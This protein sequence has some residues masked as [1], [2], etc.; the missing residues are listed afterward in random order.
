MSRRSS[1]NNTETWSTITFFVLAAPFRLTNDG[2]CFWQKQG[3][4]HDEVTSEVFSL[5]CTFPWWL[6]Q[7]PYENNNDHVTLWVISC[8]LLFP[9][10]VVIFHFE[11]AH[12]LWG[13][14]VCQR[15]RGG[16]WL[17]FPFVSLKYIHTALRKLFKMLIKSSRVLKRITAWGLLRAGGRSLADAVSPGV[18]RHR[19]AA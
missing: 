12:V 4:G 19:P 2:E 8:V 15:E 14:T 16:N 1:N 13:V 3:D 6:A 10:G 9:K 18:K 7:T 17:Q 5:T 11:C